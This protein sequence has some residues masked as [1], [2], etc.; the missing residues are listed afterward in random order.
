MRKRKYRKLIIYILCWVLIYIICT[1]IIPIIMIVNDMD[2]SNDMFG[3][4]LE[5]Y[6]KI[7]EIKNESVDLNEIFNN[8]SWDRAYLVNDEALSSEAL[9][10]ILGITCDIPAYS[11]TNFKRIIFI[12]GDK[13][14]YEFLYDYRY[15]DFSPD[16]GFVYSDDAAY[17]I[18]DSYGDSISLIKEWL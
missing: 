6:E 1:V 15:L 5:Y 16:T 3:E 2:T 9:N 17:E 7:V 11:G 18:K 4:H 12:D 13:C 10:P 8:F 14:V